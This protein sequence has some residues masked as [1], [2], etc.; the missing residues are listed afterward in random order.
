M[1]HFGR[2]LLI[3]QTRWQWFV[4]LEIAPNKNA[5]QCDDPYQWDC[6]FWIDFHGFVIP[7]EKA[8]TP[9]IASTMAVP[10]TQAITSLN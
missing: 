4:D 3:G 2:D 8:A 1:S 7:T 10:N 9:M 5:K 6:D